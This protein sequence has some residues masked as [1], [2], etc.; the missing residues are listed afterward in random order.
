MDTTNIKEIEVN[1]ITYVEKGAAAELPKMHKDF[2][3]VRTENA[4]V[5][6]GNIES[7]SE[8]GCGEV[9]NA[10]R[11]W[12]WKG[13]SSLSQL[14]QE[15]VKFPDECKFAM[16]VPHIS[17]TQIIEIIPCTK[18]AFDNIQAVPVWKQ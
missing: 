16:P 4:G 15:G 2:C 18:A 17:L 7:V 11:I 8:S 12:Y 9:L 14:S 13:A 5:F 3:I 10:I 1:G 6:A